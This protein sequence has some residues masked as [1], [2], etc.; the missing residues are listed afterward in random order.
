MDKISKKKGKKGSKKKLNPKAS[1]SKKKVKKVSA[2]VLVI[3]VAKKGTGR[4]TVRTT[5]QV[6]SI[7]KQMLLKICI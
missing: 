2:G 5:L 1:T 4:G 7:R 3:S 6:R